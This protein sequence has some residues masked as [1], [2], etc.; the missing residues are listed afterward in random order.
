MSFRAVG[1]RGPLD[2]APRLEDVIRATT[3]AR[4]GVGDPISSGGS[5]TEATGGGGGWAMSVLILLA[6]V[7][8]AT[9]GILTVRA[10][11]VERRVP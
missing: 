2:R 9:G 5:R 6:I 3:L 4:D 7:V 8:Y 1:A 10:V 11:H